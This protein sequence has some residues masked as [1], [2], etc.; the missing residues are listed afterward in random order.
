MKYFYPVILE[1]DEEDE[2]W[3]N[4]T[5]PDIFGGVTCGEGEE[6]AIYMAK[7]MIK[8]MLEEAPGQCFP[9]K[10]LEETQKNFPDKKVILV[11]VDI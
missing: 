3:L 5:V 11:E 2:K 6:D 9:P 1:P 8:L 7:D 4:V 10:S